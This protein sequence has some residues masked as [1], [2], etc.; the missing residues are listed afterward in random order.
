MLR[1]MGKKHQFCSNLFL[2]LHIN[3]SFP[4]LESHM[5]IVVFG[6]LVLYF[7]SWI[8]FIVFLPIVGLI[9]FSRLYARS[10]F[11]HQIIGSWISGVL[12]LFMARS[13]CERINFDRF[14]TDI[15]KI[16][17]N[18]SFLKNGSP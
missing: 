11:G 15:F 16:I 10:R 12:G 9:G 13:L 5:S 7:K 2:F 3:H 4:S 1:V 6:H 18:N 17:I 14:M 8:L